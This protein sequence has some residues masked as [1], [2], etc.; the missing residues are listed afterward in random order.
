MF[1]QDRFV[2]AALLFLA[3]A[4]VQALA[5]CDTL[6][7]PVIVDARAALASGDVTPVLKWIGKE[8]E[9]EIKAAFAAARSAGPGNG[10]KGKAETAFF[11]ILVR[12]HRAGE[13]APYTGLKPAGTDPGPA[14]RAADAALVSGD[15]GA[16]AKL[17]AGEVEAGIRRRFAEAA[18]RKR[19]AGESV[20]KGRAYVAAYV[21]YV[22]YVES[23]HQI[24]VGGKAG[25]DDEGGGKPA[26]GAGCGAHGKKE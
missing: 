20:E 15:A 1:H 24:A 2:L 21:E 18:E 17:V 7:G 25:H 6:D 4:P 11:E 16:V 10:A 8:R 9:A 3:F 5:H 22:H 26:C 13:G 14:V 19:H 12:V 23:L